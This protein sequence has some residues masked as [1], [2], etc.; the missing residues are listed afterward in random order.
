MTAANNP[1][2]D[3]GNLTVESDSITI[4]D[5]RIRWMRGDTLMVER[6]VFGAEYI[7]AKQRDE[8]YA[9]MPDLLAHAKNMQE[10]RKVMA[11]LYQSAEDFMAIYDEGNAPD[12]EQDKSLRDKMS[13]AFQWLIEDVQSC[14]ERDKLIRSA[15]KYGGATVAATAAQPAAASESVDTPEFRAIFRGLLGRYGE[16]WSEMITHIH[17]WHAA[18][19]PAANKQCSHLIAR[20]KLYKATHG[21][22][23]A[24]AKRMVE[25]GQ[26]LDVEGITFTAQ[27]KIEAL[28]AIKPAAA[29]GEAAEPIERFSIYEDHG[30]ANMMGDDDGDYVL[31]SHHVE[32]MANTHPAP[33]KQE[34][35][36]A[37]E[38]PVDASNP[39]L[40]ELIEGF[41]ELNMPNYGDDEVSEL[42]VWGIEVC[43][44]YGRERAAPSPQAPVTLDVAFNRAKYS[45]SVSRED[46][47]A[48]WYA[49]K[50]DGA[51]PAAEKEGGQEYDATVTL[52]RR[53]VDLQHTQIAALEARLTAAADAGSRRLDA[54]AVR[55]ISRAV[56]YLYENDCSGPAADL[57]ALLDSPAPTAPAKQADALDA[58]RYRWL[59]ENYARGDGFNDLDVALNDGDPEK[60]NQAIDARIAAMSAQPDDS[61]GQG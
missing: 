15:A 33:A 42:N 2:P 51:R 61:G 44:A 34:G 38:Q 31:Y 6:S 26:D 53:T 21:V 17:A 52:L 57:K 25:A 7:L 19:K 47:E 11:Q 24:E 3:I 1:M 32:A 35:T 30:R 10:A 49:A 56:R 46:F 29:S 18:N 39:T 60:I 5:G 28:Q 36:A 20:I 16:V 50:Q 37:S 55:A 45:R 40:S 59:L 27:A 12:S 14:V 43:A 13:D 23:T 4:V 54:E 22:S 48:G 41:P 9:A 8:A 58:A